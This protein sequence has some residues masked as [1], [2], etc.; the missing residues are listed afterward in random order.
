MSLPGNDLLTAVENA[1]DVQTLGTK[2]GQYIRRYLAPSVQNTAKSAAVGANG[3]IPAPAAPESI[4]V[5]TAGE[6]AQV[7][8][9]H[10]APIQRGVR[11]FTTIATNP[12]FIGAIVHDHGSS[13][14]PPPIYLPTKDGSGNTHSY[15]FGTVVQYPGSPPSKPTYYGGVTPVAVT[16]SGTTQMTLQAGTGSGTASNGN[17][18]FQGLGKAAVRL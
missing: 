7:V 3:D 16:M 4:S 6:L 15:Y 13:R 9:N 14:C 11:Y 18:P 12:Q 5:T 17:Q 1:Q 2:L 8:V 10:T